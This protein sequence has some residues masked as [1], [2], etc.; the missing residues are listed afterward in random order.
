MR[1]FVFDLYGTLIDIRTDEASPRF[2]RGFSRYFKKITGSDEDIWA[3]LSG[4]FEDKG[5][6]EAD[7]LIQL[8]SI[9]A[10]L[11][12]A[13]AEWKAV[14]LARY[15]RKNSV[16]RLRLYDGVTDML[17]EVKSAGAK[18]YVLSNAQSAF[19]L[20]EMRELKIYGLFD[21]VELSSD[22]GFKKPSRLFFDHLLEKYG[23]KASDCVYFGN[24][25]RADIIP[26]KALGMR[27][28]YIRTDIS[29]AEDSAA[30]ASRYAEFVSDNDFQ[31]LRQIAESL[32]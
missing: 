16:K 2:R 1:N 4:F 6:E 8:V 29:P 3:L 17:Q 10:R 9:L 13:D 19:T 28:A 15:F 22:F 23:L 7:I 24:D 20:D 31:K 5:E 18:M 12:V 26:A 27:T 25:I 30:V 14:L 21:G 32:L 11:G